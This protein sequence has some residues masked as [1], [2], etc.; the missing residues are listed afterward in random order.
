MAKLM[1][2]HIGCDVSLLCLLQIPI[3][4]ASQLGQSGIQD[5]PP[6]VR[7]VT[8]FALKRCLCVDKRGSD[9][10]YAVN[11]LSTPGTRCRNFSHPSNAP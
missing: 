4:H 11:T 5:V 1:S 7:L 3:C 6:T 2:V 9:L 8:S 10:L